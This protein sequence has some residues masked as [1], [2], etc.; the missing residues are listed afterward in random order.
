MFAVDQATGATRPSSGA[1]KPDADG[2]SA[3]SE[4]ALG[5]EGLSP[6][7]LFLRSTG[8]LA[9]LP[10]GSIR[11]IAGLDAVGD[12][13]PRDVPDHPTNAAHAL[14]TGMAGI[15]KGARLD[16]QK[17]IAEMPGLS[18]VRPLGPASPTAPPAS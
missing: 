2:V 7:A 10:V 18:I 8:A 4:M 15:S 16:L 13:W 5:A 14:I 17:A 11:R 6:S 12:P 3:Y 1:F 9:R